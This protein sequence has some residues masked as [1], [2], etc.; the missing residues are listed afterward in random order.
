MTRGLLLFSSAVDAAIATL[1]TLLI[2]AVLVVVALGAG[3]VL[4]RYAFSY[5]RPWMSESF[6]WLNGII[7]M[8]GTPYLLQQDRHVRVDVIYGQVS[9]RAKAAINLLGVILILWPSCYALSLVIWPS[10]RRS[11]TALEASPTIDGLPFLYILKACVPLFFVLLALQGA[12]VAARALVVLARGE[13][14]PQPGDR[15]G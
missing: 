8:L 6:V 3:V 13:V 9:E 2:R 1:G 10:V 12:S 5:G 7:F 11:L 4:L 15:R 14:P